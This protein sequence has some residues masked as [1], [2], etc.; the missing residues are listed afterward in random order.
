MTLRHR[1]TSALPRREVKNG[2]VRTA[3]PHIALGYG[4]GVSAE[5]PA[6]ASPILLVDDDDLLVKML[7]RSLRSAGYH[8]TTAPDAS[9]ALNLAASLSPAVLVADAIL[10]DGNGWS[11]ARRLREENPALGVVLISGHSRSELSNMGA[12]PDNSEFL[13][14]PFSRDALA[15]ALKK[16][17]PSSQA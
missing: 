15:L 17:S 7:T 4:D 2:G 12:P 14:K 3:D 10:P 8:V 1:K 9:T 5:I 13:Q 16:V 11:I 6:T